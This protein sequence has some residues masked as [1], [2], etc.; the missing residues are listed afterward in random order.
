MNAVP[1]PQLLPLCNHLHCLFPCSKHKNPP[2]ELGEIPYTGKKE[3]HWKYVICRKYTNKFYLTGEM[4]MPVLIV[5]NVLGGLITVAAV[6]AVV[7]GVAVVAA[8]VVVIQS[9]FLI[10]R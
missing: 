2:Q 8:A 9:C 5:Q 3:K 7:V 4:I 6:R 1:R 10:F